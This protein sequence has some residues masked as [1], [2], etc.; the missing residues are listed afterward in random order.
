MDVTKLYAG[1]SVVSSHLF[2]FALL[3]VAIP[4]AAIIAIR[5]A[6][7]IRA[8]IKDTPPPRRYVSLQPDNPSQSTL[9]DPD[10]LMSRDRFQTCHD[11]AARKPGPRRRF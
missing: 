3:V 1:W 2:V 4:F 5:I 11:N 7:A 10:S 6:L 9:L 8:S